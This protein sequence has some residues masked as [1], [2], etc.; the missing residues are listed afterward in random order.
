MSSKYPSVRTKRRMTLA[1]SWAARFT[2]RRSVTRISLTRRQVYRREMSSWRLTVLL[3]TTWLWR[4]QR[5]W[6][7][8]AKTNFSWLSSEKTTWSS[9]TTVWPTTI[10]VMGVTTLT[11]TLLDT[12]F[13]RMDLLIW[14]T[15]MLWRTVFSTLLRFLRQVFGRPSIKMSMF[16]LQ[17]DMFQDNNNNSNS[18]AWIKETTWVKCINLLLLQLNLQDRMFPMECLLL[19]QIK[20]LLLEL[21]TCLDIQV[22]REEDLLLEPIVPLPLKYQ[23]ICR[24][25]HLL[26]HFMLCHP[27]EAT[28]ME[29]PWT[30]VTDPVSMQMTCQT[31]LP[32][33]CPDPGDQLQIP[34][35]LT[36]ESFPSKRKA[37]LESVWQEAMK[38]VSL[39]QVSS[40]EVLLQSKDYNRETRFLK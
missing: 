21:Q 13:T 15:E 30:A 22:L 1:L 6:L 8:L 12:L 20:E 31:W 23:H 37:Q 34:S 5:S 25:L 35:P 18:K 28:R 10:I 17:R 33:K 7:T 36:L 9:T 24:L 4:R 14:P 32:W 27:R 2:S 29:M 39:S 3:W 38:L 19:L 11:G 40:R 16:S 26:L